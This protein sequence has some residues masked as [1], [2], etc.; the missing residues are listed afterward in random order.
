MLDSTSGLSYTV[1]GNRAKSQGL[2]VSLEARPFKGTTLSTWFVFDDA[3]LSQ[4]FPANSSAYGVDGERLPYGSRFSDYFSLD[5]EF[6]LTS[7]VSGFT[8]AALSYI[9]NRLG[10]FGPAGSTPPPRQE[11]G[12]YA[13][14]D[15]KAGARFPSWTTNLFVNNVTDRRGA[16]TGGIGY[17][18]PF[19]FVYI[20]PRT[21]GVSVIR[22][23]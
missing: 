11:F 4:N 15:V 2:E 21:F 20:Q 18:P 17:T 10:I 23:F 9:G 12:G 5:Q 14:L 19:A 3:Q 7:Q 1:N 22:T 13:R 8:G 16:L 6:P